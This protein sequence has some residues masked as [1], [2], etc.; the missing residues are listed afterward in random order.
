MDAIHGHPW[1]QLVLGAL[2]MA[3]GM[4]IGFVLTPQA[5]DHVAIVGERLDLDRP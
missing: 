2:L 1:R 5:P 3:L 4:A